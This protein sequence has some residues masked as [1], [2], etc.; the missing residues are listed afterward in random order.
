MTDRFADERRRLGAVE[1][2]LAALQRQY[3]LAMSAFKFEESAALQRRM[4]ALEREHRALAEAL[5]PSPAGPEPPI[6]VVP[7]LRRPRRVRRR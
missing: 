7:V 5:P 6:G 3:E 4:N 2:E 1:S